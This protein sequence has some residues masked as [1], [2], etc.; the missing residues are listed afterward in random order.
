[1]AFDFSLIP[2]LVGLGTSVAGAIPGLKKP[3]RDKLSGRAAAEAATKV[4]SAAVGGAQAGQ[5]ASRGL[6]LRQGLRSAL[7]P[8]AQG[9]AAAEGIQA[10]AAF[11]NR[12][13][14][15]NQ[16]IADF[17]G[18]AAEGLAQVG[19]AFIQPK[20]AEESQ[21]LLQEQPEFQPSATGLDTPAA[22][23]APSQQALTSTAEGLADP[24]GLGLGD[25]EQQFADEAA[26][27][28]A[29]FKSTA[30]LERLISQAPSVAAPEIEA[31]LDNRLQAKKLMLQDAERLGINLGDVLAN[32][33]RKL[34]LSPGQSVDNPFGVNL[35]FDQGQDNG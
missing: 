35:S 8:V 15:R 28:A 32:I 24:Q 29:D 4:A 31:D 2:S 10:E 3:K 23:V 11:Q 9:S 20:S 17:T 22:G 18:G 6:A 1:M 33:N 5:G 21:A 14:E 12:V 25:I 30:A 13:D 19:Q 26:G 16:R 7:D 27:P 34:G